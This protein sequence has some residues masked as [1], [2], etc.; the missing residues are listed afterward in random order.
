[1]PKTVYY[2]GKDYHCHD[3]T[4]CHDHHYTFFADIGND[5]FE[6]DNVD[7]LKK[8]VD[9]DNVQH[10]PPVQYYHTIR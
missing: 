10:L 8:R 3:E 5:K 6:F 9:H 7:E 2:T 1:M 4:C